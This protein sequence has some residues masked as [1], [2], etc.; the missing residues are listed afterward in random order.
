MTLIT[1]SGSVKPVLLITLL[2]V[3]IAI[4]VVGGSLLNSDNSAHSS[5]NDAQGKSDDANKILYWVAPMDSSYRRD[6]PGKSPMGMDLVPVYASEQTDSPGTVSISPV[7]EQSL[8]VTTASAQFESLSESVA[9]LGVIGFNQDNI[10]HVHPRV[11]GWIEYLGVNN[12]G[13]MVQKGEVLYRLY[14]PELVNAQEEYLLALNRNNQTLIKAARDKLVALQLPESTIESVTRNRMVSQQVAFA[15]PQSG[16]VAKLNVR[17]GF[18]VEPGITLMEIASQDEVWLTTEVP[19]RQAAQ[20]QSGQHAMVTLDTYPDQVFHAMVDYVYPVMNAATRTLQVRLRLPNTQKKL[21]PNMFAN[22]V[23]LISN[24]EMVL[25]VPRHAVI[26]TAKNNRVVLALGD[27]KYKSVA[28]TLGNINS[29]SIEIVDGLEE[30]DRVVTNAQFLLDSESAIDSD[31]ARYSEGSDNSQSDTTRAWVAAEINSV[32]AE[33]RTVNASHEAIE[34][35]QWPAMV[36]DFA[37]ADDVDINQLGAG[38]TLHM[39]IDKSASGLPVITGIHIM[40]GM[41]GPAME[42]SS[43]NTSADTQEVQSATVNGVINYIDAESRVLNVSRGAIEKWGREPATLDFTADDS[44]QLHNLKAGQAIEFTFEIR[45][46]EF[47]IVDINEQ[48]NATSS[49][50]AHH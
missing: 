2:F 40:S 20:I 10:I 46:G 6:G 32:D 4:G 12:E 27:G 1:S 22:V 9:A 13:Q 17:P 29:D 5:M 11:K 45:D 37:V 49:A 18:Y 36:M 15:A 7:I 14:S 8:G 31:L 28:V 35:W 3:G 50:H 25:T 24:D 48:I 41:A 39:E 21:K 47:V 43:M 16:I 33:S 23:F 44:V 30:G 34:D 42:E 19:E 38:V 26:R